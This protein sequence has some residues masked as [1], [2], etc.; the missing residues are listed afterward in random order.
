MKKTYF[1]YIK[2]EFMQK[3]KKYSF[4]I[5]LLVFNLTI[6]NADPL[7]S[8]SASNCLQQLDTFLSD[9]QNYYE[10]QI[11]V[12]GIT[13]RI[14]DNNQINITTERNSMRIEL[15]YNNEVMMIAHISKSSSPSDSDSVNFD[16]SQRFGFRTIYTKSY[17][18]FEQLSIS[19]I[20]ISLFE[21]FGLL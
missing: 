21:A 18:R 5:M 19:L 14:R 1:N 20:F 3:Y 17:D 16:F 13:G 11:S 6:L 2:G 7:N 4:L 12:I 15:L 9:F 10:I 8:R